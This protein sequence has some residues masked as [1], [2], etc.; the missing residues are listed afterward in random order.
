M[1]KRNLIPLLC[2]IVAEVACGNRAAISPAQKL[3]LAT[4]DGQHLEVVEMAKEMGEL[5]AWQQKRKAGTARPFDQPDGAQAFF[6]LKR[7]AQDQTALNGSTLI[8]A[9][10]AAN[11]MS[12]Y[13]TARRSLVPRDS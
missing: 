7:L 1:H 9:A 12:V 13:S 3:R 2:L 6:V 11:S 8:A 10:D 4:R 5:S